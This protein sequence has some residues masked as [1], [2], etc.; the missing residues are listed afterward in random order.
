M[1]N[2]I[3]VRHGLKKLGGRRD[4]RVALILANARPIPFRQ[5]VVLTADRIFGRNLSLAECRAEM[6]QF[7]FISVLGFL[8]V[9]LRLNDDVVMDMSTGQSDRD[10][11]IRR[12]L[13]LL[14]DGE[15]F[16]RALREWQETVSGGNHF[17]P[18]SSPALLGLMEFAGGHCA[19]DGGISVTGR[20]AWVILSF[21]SEL[22]SRSVQDTAWA[23]LN[24]ADASLVI[25]ADLVRNRLAH[26]PGWYLRNCMARLYAFAFIPAVGAKLPAGATQATWFQEWF[27]MAAADY[28]L[29]ASIMVAF[30]GQFDRQ[31]AD[32]RRIQT[33]RTQ[34]LGSLTAEFR[35]HLERL[36]ALAVRPITQIGSGVQALGSFTEIIYHATETMRRPLVALNDDALLCVSA[37]HLRN[38]YLAGL[39][40]LPLDL[41]RSPDGVLPNQVVEGFGGS[42]GLMLEGYVIWLLRQWIGADQRTQIYESYRIPALRPGDDPERDFLIVRGDVALVF[43]IKSKAV[44]LAVRH[45][46]DF[47]SLDPIFLPPAFQAYT[48][49]QALRA[50]TATT[51]TG[52]TIDGIRTVVPIAVVWDFVPLAGAFS[53]S[54]ERHLQERTARP[55]FREVDGI[56]PLQ[57]L[58]IEVLESLETFCD[59]TPTSGELFGVLLERARREEL[60][61]ATIQGNRLRGPQLGQPAPLN[62]AANASQAK[63][64]ADAERRLRSA[65]NENQRPSGQQD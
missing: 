18:L 21:Q 62:D 45:T 44:S 36:L 51:A 12:L 64:I 41:R 28:H 8:T 39:R 50:G 30:Q 20:L 38:K 1:P 49:A 26:N 11:E 27:G 35:P 52:E 13:R 31:Q 48:A 33:S 34:I 58:S 7:S 24:M 47:S 2:S 57:F 63:L 3:D 59:L 17:R 56:A 25:H 37:V 23:E 22:I 9:V 53:L 14:F 46:G 15:S 5:G 60:R 42:F 40:H 16:E 29:A 6:S 32:I 10:E 19:R 61:Y 55:M 54:Y 43:E 4:F 65:S